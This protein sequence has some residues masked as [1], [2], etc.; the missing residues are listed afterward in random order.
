MMPAGLQRAL[1]TVA[2]AVVAVLIAV[3]VSSVAILAAGASP[4]TALQAM[5]DFGD[6]Q[7]Q[8]VNSVTT[9]LNRAVPLFVAGLAV[10]IGFRMNLFNIGVEGQY[11]I[12][13]VVAA[14]V[15]SQFDLPGPVQILLIIAVAMAVGGLYALIPAVLKVTRGVNE[16]IA[17]IMLNYIAINLA[18]F[19]VRGPFA[20]ERAEGQLTTSTP[21]L[22]E[23]AWFPNLNFLFEMFGLPA[24]RGGGLWGF[25]AV[26][27]VAGLIIWLVLERTRF[28]F[29]VKA[30]GLNASAA[31]ASGIDPKRMVI[32]AMVLSGA[33]AGLIGLPEIL[34]RTHAYGSNFT[35]GLG[36]LGIAVALLGRNRPGGIAV[37]ALLFAFLDR[38]GAPLQ[39]ADIPPSVI[40]IIQGTIVLMVVIANEVTIRMSMRNEERRAARQLATTNQAGVAA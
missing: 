22:P 40:T 5:F 18:A 30:T 9:L 32:S 16:V 17:T 24:P 10:A 8:V 33:V 2:G 25:L 26:A 7:I 36:F 3:A 27:V 28:G 38:A 37:A 11:R 39:F 13:A 6:T 21:E 19:L 15:G 1:L 20:G 31:L 29:E 4:V 12:A 35:A 14:F 23:S 34:G